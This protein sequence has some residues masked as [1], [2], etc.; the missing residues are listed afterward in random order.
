VAGGPDSQGS[1]VK[2]VKR[3][4]DLWSERNAEEAKSGSPEARK[5]CYVSLTSLISSQGQ[6]SPLSARI[7]AAKRYAPR[8]DVGDPVAGLAR[9]VG[10]FSLAFLRSSRWGRWRP[11]P[12][13]MTIAYTH[14][15]S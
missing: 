6:S 9:P 13:C 2:P 7:L 10:S 14:S 8:A 3:T 5:V 15:L 4:A 1:E 12:I 11:R